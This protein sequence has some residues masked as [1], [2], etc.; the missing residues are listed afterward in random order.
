MRAI[1]GLAF[2][3][4]PAALAQGVRELQGIAVRFIS[5]LFVWAGADAARAGGSGPACGRRARVFERDQPDLACAGACGQGCFS[6]GAPELI[7]D[8]QTPI[9]GAGFVAGEAPR[10][11]IPETLTNGDALVLALRSF[12]SERQPEK[13]PGGAVDVEK[14]SGSSEEATASSVEGVAAATAPS[15]LPLPAPGVD[16]GASDSLEKYQ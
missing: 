1:P 2:D 11:C 15:P 3:T 14:G 13:A 6:R 9:L 10:A 8:A 12:S 5:Y 7:A 16:L 4:S